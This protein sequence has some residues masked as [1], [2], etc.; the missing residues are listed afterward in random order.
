MFR[1]TFIPLD[2]EKDGLFLSL[3]R[4][5]AVVV[6]GPSRVEVDSTVRYGI[7]L[8]QLGEMTPPRWSDTMSGE[9]SVLKLEH[10]VQ[11]SAPPPPIDEPQS[12]L[13]MV[14]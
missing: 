9:V 6:L 13:G 10:D 5:A 2:T 12:S 8:Q 7:V 4:A 3:S 1:R 11:Q 14:M